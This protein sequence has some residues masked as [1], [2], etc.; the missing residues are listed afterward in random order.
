MSS[1]DEWFEVSVPLDGKPVPVILRL[2]TFADIGPFTREPLGQSEA[3]RQSTLRL[4]LAHD[5][6]SLDNQSMR[7]SY[8]DR[9]MADPPAHA[10]ILQKRNTLYERGRAA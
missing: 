2:A 7:L 6:A 5:I 1:I 3:A 10:A 9:I 4:A 8:A